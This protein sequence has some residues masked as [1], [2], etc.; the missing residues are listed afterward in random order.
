MAS[1]PLST[2]YKPPRG[3]TKRAKSA[4]LTVLSVASVAL[5][6]SYA[7]A[8]TNRISSVRTIAQDEFRISFKALGQGI[9][10]RV[11]SG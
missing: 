8:A 11:S 9:R 7:S 3:W 10:R 4:L 6:Q 5:R 1:T 2:D